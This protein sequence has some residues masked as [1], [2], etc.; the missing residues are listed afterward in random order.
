[1]DHRALRWTAGALAAAGGLVLLPLVVGA[2]GPAPGEAMAEAANRFLAALTPDQKKRAH[3][4]WEDATRTQWHYVPQERAGLAFK[5]MDAKQ[6]ALGHALL[7]AGLSHAGYRKSAEIIELEKVLAEIEK[8]PVKRDPEKYHFWIYGKPEPKGTWGWKFEGHHLSLNFTIVRGTAI[9]TTPAFMGA[10]PGEVRSGPLKGRRVLGAEEDLGRELVLSFD[11]KARAQV[12]YEAKAPDEILTV[13]ASKVDPLAP[14]GVAAGSMTAKQRDILR[15]LLQ[16][17]A[18]SMPP[19]LASERLAKIDK[20]GFEKVRF[21][22]AGGLKRGDPHY[23]RIQGP[24]FLVEYDNT[25]NGAN[26]AH[27]VWRDFA[28]D[29]GRDLLREHL[30]KAHASKPAGN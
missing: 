15:R 27:T 22:W 25:Q 1:M 21:A 14:A 20:A 10:N 4:A 9:A 30:N 12:I 6:R 19:A 24:T 2:L 18:S 8:N 23:Y 11:E 3:Y 5:A 29:F 26:H 28:G 17:Y 7:K 16:E 13:A